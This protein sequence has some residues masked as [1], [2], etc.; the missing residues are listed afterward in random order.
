MK[1]LSLLVLSALLLILVVVVREPHVDA[2]SVAGVDQCRNRILNE[3]TLVRDEE[4]AHIF[5][6]RR[7]AAGKFAVLTGG[8][9]LRERKGILETRER[10]TSELVVPIVES[11]RTYR[12]KAAAVCMAVADSMHRKS[13]TVDIDLLGCETQTLTRY[14]ECYIAPPVPTPDETQG[15]LQ[16]ISTIQNECDT[17]V[18]DSLRAER[19]I[20]RLAVAYD[21]GH[22]STLQFA[23]MMDWMMEDLSARAIRPIR[24]MV[25]MLG[26]LHEIPCFIGQC[27]NPDTSGVAP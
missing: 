12:C 10:L 27:D 11:Y 8:T 13:G 4:R 22:R 20:L 16:D 15:I 24:D 14:D 3:L 17:L 2:Q 18:E 5:G 26:K 21:T 6:S 7:D 9:D 25:N 19:A 23:G 1:R